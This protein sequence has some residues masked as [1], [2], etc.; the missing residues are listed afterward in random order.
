MF[1]L[2]RCFIK[3]HLRLH[4]RNVTIKV[5]PVAPPS[6][7]SYDEMN[8]RMKRPMSPALGIYKP[9]I[10]SILS[11]THRTTGLLLSGYV[12]VLGI[13]ALVCPQDIAACIASM[14]EGF[15][16][17]SISVIALKYIF[18]FP[19]TFHGCAGIRHLIWDTGKFLSNNEVTSTGYVVIL[20]AMGLAVLLV[21]IPFE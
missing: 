1:S 14:L 5:V 17:S 12:T 3:S 19:F 7:E 2:T 13:G 4:S 15:E 18:A 8:M 9:Q 10:T 20:S 6:Q 21:M 11:L 16:L